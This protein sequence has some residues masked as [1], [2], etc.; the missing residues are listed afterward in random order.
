[1][2]EI[3]KLLLELMGGIC[4][5]NYLVSLPLS[6]RVETLPE[7]SRRSRTYAWLLVPDLLYKHDK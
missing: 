2:L 6:K 7:L 1:M 5:G 4:A 3:T